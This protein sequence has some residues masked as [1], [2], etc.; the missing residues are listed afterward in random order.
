MALVQSRL[1]ADGLQL[2]VELEEKIGAS[3]SAIIAALLDFLALHYKDEVTDFMLH[4]VEFYTKSYRFK[5]KPYK[6]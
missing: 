2:V 3:T 5:R 4:N 6:K 1:K